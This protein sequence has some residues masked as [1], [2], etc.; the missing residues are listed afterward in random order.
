MDPIS[1]LNGLTEL[2]RKRITAE[3]SGKRGGPSSRSKEAGAGRLEHKADVE[4]LREQVIR[5]MQAIDP[6]DSTRSTKTMR[7]FVESVLVWQFGTGVLSDPTFAN[8]VSDVQAALES[9]ST[10]SEALTNFV[11]EMK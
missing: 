6:A 2:L 8:L 10:V 5:S 9:D 11:A 7:V 3:A 4:A 1:P